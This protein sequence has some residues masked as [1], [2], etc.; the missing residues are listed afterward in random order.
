MAGITIIV[1]AEDASV[2]EEEE[3]T[4][5]I[6]SSAQIIALFQEGRISPADLD[7]YLADF[8]HSKYPDDK[9]EDTQQRV[10]ITKARFSLPLTSGPDV[11]PDD[12]AEADVPLHFTPPTPTPT[13]TPTRVSRWEPYHLPENLKDMSTV[14][15]GLPEYTTGEAQLPAPTSVSTSVPTSAPIFDV[16]DQHL[17]GGRP[18][19]G[20]EPSLPFSSQGGAPNVTLPN[21]VN[22]PT[23]E[24]LKTQEETDR[25]GVLQRFLHTEPKLAGLSPFLIERRLNRLPDVFSQ[26]LLSNLVRAGE[27]Q[28]RAV[29]TY[30]NV[31]S[32]PDQSNLGRPSFED[33]LRGGG[34]EGFTPELGRQGVDLLSRF[35]NLEKAVA[36]G[37][38]AS[39]G[40]EQLTEAAHALLGD[41]DLLENALIQSAL[42]RSAPGFSAPLRRGA[43]KQFRLFQSLH[44]GAPQQKLIDFARR[45][46][47]S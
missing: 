5:D 33:F 6:T 40:W 41:Q 29:D 37:G 3:E 46:G 1:P 27:L 23:E 24:E 43:A 2:R 31:V 32:T 13:P 36:A 34:T 42:S 21:I 45:T 20:G 25:Y 14:S 30:G 19:G 47:Y 4:I 17:L 15:R 18:W 26:H 35:L 28:N 7:K 12:V 9:D 11:P 44:P 39:E 38:P 22:I 8:Y 16:Y 10:G